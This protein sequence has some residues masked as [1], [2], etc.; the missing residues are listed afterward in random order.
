[1]I[2]Q[3][4]EE[5]ELLILSLLSKRRRKRRWTVRPPNADRSVM[6]EF[7][8]LVKPM[9]TLDEGMHF[10][11]FGMSAH[12]FDELLRRVEPL[13]RHERTHSRPVGLQERLA[14]TLRLLASGNSQR[15]VAESYKLGVST[16]SRIVS[17]MCSA[18]WQALEEDYVS[19][20]KGTE[21]TDIAQDFWRLWNF[22]NCVGCI[23]DRRVSVRKSSD[24]VYHNDA[25]SIELFATCDAHHRF[26]MV[27][28]S[29]YDC[30]NEKR[31]FRISHFGSRLL[32]KTLEL[33]E[34]VA[35]PGSSA[36]LPHVFLGDAAFPLH[37]NL[38]RPY[39]GVNL[40]DAQKTYNYRHSRALKV[41]ENTFDI[42][43]AR[44]KILGRP[45]EYYPEKAVDVVKA[46]IALHNMLAHNDAAESPTG[47][48]YIP[49]N[50]TDNTEAS[51]VLI[52][53]D[54]RSPVTRHT[55]LR[56]PGRVSRT[57]ASNTAIAARNNL[58]SFFLTPQGLL[59]M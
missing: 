46:C 48:R 54:W 12:R 6:G 43:V 8:V 21:W 41:I 55:N 26:T 58:K 16:V 59:P 42:L 14:V 47:R 30:E 37:E 22:P 40:D 29:S 17:E 45:I 56:H 53:G 38:M 27:D 5:E 33:P 35:L 11:Y 36:K 23:D 2:L 10:G 1:M 51:G 39:S 3:M 49:P 24:S 20:P 50:L 52:P 32:N 57:R 44:W 7:S 15:S 25:Q 28:I 19:L 34:P 4:F 9:R 18:I 31:I 13:V